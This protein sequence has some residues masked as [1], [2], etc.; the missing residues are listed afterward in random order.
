MTYEAKRR[1]ARRFV[2]DVNTAITE[3]SSNLAD[4]I[5]I[6]YFAKTNMCK[7]SLFFFSFDLLTKYNST[8]M[9]IT[10]GQ[11]SNIIFPA[12]KKI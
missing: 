4:N 9:I 6:Q 8:K 3:E 1:T 2:L 5:L 11:L 7:F 12:P 10:S